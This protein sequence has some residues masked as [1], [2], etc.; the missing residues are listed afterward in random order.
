MWAFRTGAL[1]AID[2]RF[3][4]R[5]TQATLGRYLATLFRSLRSE[6]APDHWYSALQRHD[7]SVDVLFDGE[8][9]ARAGGIPG[10]AE[11]VLSH[12]DRQALVTL[13]SGRLVLGAGAVQHGQAGVVLLGPSHA[14]V[15]A[16]VQAGLD[17]HSD[18][19]VVLDQ[20]A[21]TMYP[22]PTPMSRRPSLSPGDAPPAASERRPG[23]RHQRQ[24]LPVDSVRHQ[25]VGSACTPG[26][27]VVASSRGG[28]LSALSLDPRARPLS[29][30]R[31]AKVP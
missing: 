9:L 25:A 16:L 10:T 1:G 28:A 29:V 21:T 5:S 4:V 20:A 11:V 6:D 26:V 14:L 27:V 24:L 2:Y 23:G 22:Y 30:R 3:A 12:V 18:T 31:P 17:Y 7:G 8:H 13:R 15:H 19:Y